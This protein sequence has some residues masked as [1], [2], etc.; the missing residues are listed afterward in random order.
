MNEKYL[1]EKSKEIRKTCLLKMTE[2]NSSHIG[3]VFSMIDIVTY[4]FYEEMNLE[5]DKFVLS[6]GHAVAGLYTVLH[7]KGFISDEE[8]KTYHSDNSYLI[9]HPNHVVNGVDVSTGSLGHGLAIAAGLA[10]SNELDKSSGRVYCLLGDGECQEGSVWE[11]LI[12]VARNLFRNIVIIIDA[13]NYQGFSDTCDSLFSRKKLFQ[14]LKSTG[15]DVYEINGH[16]FKEINSAL[17]GD[18]DTPRVLLANTIKGKGVSYMENR[19]EWH[20]KTPNS[21]QLKQALKELR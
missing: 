1:K 18:F 14:M 9:A 19:F 17:M 12:F 5:T 21:K 2:A 10:W 15:L 6:K 13:N 7:K 4:L 20:Y 8:Y 3:C 16:N 11:S